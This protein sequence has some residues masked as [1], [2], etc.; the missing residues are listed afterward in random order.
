[1]KYLFVLMFLSSSLL[2]GQQ[3]P[4]RGVPRL[5]DY[6]VGQYGNPGKI[7]SIAATDNGLIYCAS[8]AGLL[9]FD[10]HE[11]RQFQGSKGFVRSLLVVSDSVLYTGSDKDFGRWERS[12]LRDMRYTSLYP[13]RESTQGVNEEFWGVH[14]LGEDIIFVSFD[15]LYVLREG[16]LTKIAAPYRFDRSFFVK[17]NL[18]LADEKYGLYRFNGM[19][20]E[21]VF[22]YTRQDPLQ[23]VGVAGEGERLLVTTRDDGQFSFRNGQLQPITNE[24]TPYLKRDQVFSYAAI[25]DTHYAFGTILNGVYITDHDGRIIQHINKQ[26]GLPNNTVLALYY[27]RQGRLWLSMDFG[28]AVVHLGSDLAYVLDYRGEFGTGQTAFLRG[29][30]FY[31]GTNQGLYRTDWDRLQN[32]AGERGL[33]LVAGSAGQVWALEE[34]VGQLLCGHDRGLFRVRNGTLERLYGDD[35]VWA[36]EL[37]DADHLLAGTYDGVVLFR[38]KGDGWTYLRKMDPLLGACAQLEVTDPRTMW[39]HVPNYG[40]I[41]ATLDADRRVV[42]QQIFPTSDFSGGQPQLGQ[43]DGQVVVLTSTQRYVYQSAT[44]AFSRT[45]TPNLAAGIR[46]VL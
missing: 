36:I 24:V 11:W 5:D 43:E 4:E 41:R 45:P 13:F 2:C 22:D 10:G 14:Q 38:R 3:F 1:M 29:E 25:D 15:N 39:V 7:W 17:D 34:V 27:S 18:Y 37:L 20:L 21:A 31:L 19:S 16:Q 44:G 32:D 26:K 9:E 8:D 23:I 6:L 33:R 28:L 46:N 42:E 35:G 12:G 40:I 30:D